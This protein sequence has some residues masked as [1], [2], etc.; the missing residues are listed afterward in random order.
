MKEDADHIVWLSANR[1][2]YV[3]SANGLYS[4]LSP[5]GRG[6]PDHLEQDEVA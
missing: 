5:A 3:T 2:K 4:I 6:E 1:V